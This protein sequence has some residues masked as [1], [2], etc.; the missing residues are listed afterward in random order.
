MFKMEKS[1]SEK[2]LMIS[3]ENIADEK[4]VVI[5]LMNGSYAKRSGRKN[6]L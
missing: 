1:Y 4:T 5:L 3:N 6:S 2:N